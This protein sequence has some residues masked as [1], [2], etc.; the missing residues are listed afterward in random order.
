MIGSSMSR[1]TWWVSVLFMSDPPLLGVASLTCCATQ[2]G[3][4]IL[5]P[6]RGLQPGADSYGDVA[7]LERGLFLQDAEE[8][9]GGFVQEKRI[10]HFKSRNDWG[11]RF[12]TSVTSGQL[13]LACNYLSS[14]F[15]M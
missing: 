6:L 3:L 9:I 7:L 13:F 5:K 2:Q 1:T 12:V 15:C 10:E 4:L 8:K 11:S 14:V